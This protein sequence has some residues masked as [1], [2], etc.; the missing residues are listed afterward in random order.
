MDSE[1]LPY[2][3]S[4]MI[5]KLLIVLL[6]EI[7]L[8][9][10]KHGLQDQQSM[11]ISFNRFHKDVVLSNVLQNN[12][13]INK[14]EENVTIVLQHQFSNLVIEDDLFTVNVVIDKKNTFVKIPFESVNLFIDP[15]AALCVHMDNKTPNKK[16]NSMNSNI[17]YPDFLQQLNKDDD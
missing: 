13:N 7:L 11:M 14:N 17:I 8:K 9:I 12:K 10:Q 5:Q 15:C 2:D 1:N 3:Y 6:K 16:A 4:P